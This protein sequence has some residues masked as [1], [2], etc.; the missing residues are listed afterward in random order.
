M[1]SFY[2]LYTK[3][4]LAVGFWHRRCFP[5]HW[6]R[7]LWSIRLAD[8]SKRLWM[9]QFFVC[10]GSIALTGCNVHP[11]VDDVSPIPN[12][13]IIASARCELRLGL[14]SAVKNWFIDDKITDFNPDFLG[15]QIEA[16][17][18]RY[19]GNPAWVDRLKGY[20][21]YL[22]IAVAYN[23]NFEITEINSE[24]VKVGFQIPYLNPSA[25]GITAGKTNTKTRLAK[26][27][28][29]TGETF[30]ALL[31][32]GLL[33]FLQGRT[34]CGCQRLSAGRANSAAAQHPLSDHWLYRA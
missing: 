18:T 1:F 24:D 30:A 27:T 7:H 9:Q 23:W 20:E 28:F 29:M 31:T 10:L 26:R 17:K 22:A 12:E 8:R 32:P 19:S 14:V 2:A 4:L 15:D 6:Q 16:L 13:N 5:F 11:I 21:S 33:R 25:F 3:Y 34:E